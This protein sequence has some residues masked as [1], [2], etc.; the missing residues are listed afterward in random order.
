MS[1]GL[2]ELLATKRKA[3]T[4]RHDSKKEKKGVNLLKRL[5]EKTWKE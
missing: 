4:N 2:H 1:K 3:T 5:R